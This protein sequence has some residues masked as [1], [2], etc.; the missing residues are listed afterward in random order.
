MVKF[1]RITVGD[2]TEGFKLFPS[3]RSFLIVSCLPRDYSEALTMFDDDRTGICVCTDIAIS[4]YYFGIFKILCTLYWIY[5]RY[6]NRVGPVT[7]PY[8]CHTTESTR[9]AVGFISYEVF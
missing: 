1:R 3:Y 7:D 5:N 2:Q 4:A 6:S 9:T 8:R